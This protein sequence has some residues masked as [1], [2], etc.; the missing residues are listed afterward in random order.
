MTLQRLPAAVSVVMLFHVSQTRPLAGQAEP[1]WRVVNVAQRFVDFI[2]RRGICGADWRAQAAAFR[3]E[4]VAGDS[5]FFRKAVGDLND[6]RV[7]AFLC[8]ARHD[9]A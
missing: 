2:D 3:R 4:V 7:D 8:L 5:A 9:T 6:E 1:T